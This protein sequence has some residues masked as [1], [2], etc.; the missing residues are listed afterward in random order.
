[1]P[2]KRAVAASTV[3][4]SLH[5]TSGYH[6]RWVG[7][8]SANRSSPVDSSQTMTFPSPLAAATSPSTLTSITDSG[9]QVLATGPM[10]PPARPMTSRPSPVSASQMV[11]DPSPLGAITPVPS[12]VNATPGQ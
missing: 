2:S 8:E 9:D 10:S 1:M 6:P 5:A 12:E 4:P 3:P 7:T 11:A